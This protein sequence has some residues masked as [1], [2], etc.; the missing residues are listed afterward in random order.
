MR[1]SS[2]SRIA[3]LAGALMVAALPAVAMAQETPATPDS[4]NEIQTGTRIQSITVIGA[5]RDARAPKRAERPAD[6]RLP[7]LPVTYEDGAAQPGR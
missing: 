5:I 1:K 6:T 2:T 4:S 7:E 3:A